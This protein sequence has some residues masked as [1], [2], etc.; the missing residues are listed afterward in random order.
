MTF[1]TIISSLTVFFSILVKVI[2]F[3][4]QA[5]KIYLQKSSKGQSL[6]LYIL[7]FTVYILWTIY[8]IIKQDWVII[9]G[10]VLGVITTGI[11]LALLLKYHNR[12]E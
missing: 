5:R 4:D 2:G 11:I 9:G 8:G 12:N 7:S 1:E 10:Q 3:P 6:V